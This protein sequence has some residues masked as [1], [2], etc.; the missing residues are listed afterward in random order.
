MILRKFILLQEFTVYMENSLHFEI[1]LR[2]IWAKWNL[3][4]NEFHYMRSHVNAD[5]EVTSY[6]SEILPQSEISNWFE[7]TSG[8]M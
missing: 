6:R 5:N 8:L 7:F 4:Q 1:S 3:H 2:S